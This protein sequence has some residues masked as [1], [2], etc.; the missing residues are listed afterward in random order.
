MEAAGEWVLAGSGSWQWVSGSWQ[1]VSGFWQWVSGSWQ[2]VSGFWLAVGE[3]VLAAGEW[4]L[5]AGEWVL[6]GSG[7]WQWVS[8]SWQ[9]VSGSWQWV[10]GSWQRVSGFWQWVSG[11]WQWVSGFWLAVG[12]WVLAAG[13]WVLA[14]GEWVLAGSGSW[15]WVSGSWQRVSGS[16]QWVSGSWQRVSGF[17][18]WVSG[19]WQWV[20]GFW[21]WVSGSWQWVS[22]SWQRVSGSWQW[23]SGSWQ[24]V[25]AVGERLPPGTPWVCARCGIWVWEGGGAVLAMCCPHPLLP[26]RG[27]LPPPSLPASPGTLAMAAPGRAQRSGLLE[28]RGPGERWLRVLVLLGE[29]T[30]SFTPEPEPGLPEEKAVNGGE[31]DHGNVPD[32]IINLRRTVRVVKQEAGGLGVSIKGGRENKMPILISKIFK[33][34]AADLTGAL[35]IGDAI[36]SV[37]GADLS[38]ATHDDAVQALKKTG[39]EVVLEVKYMKE[40]SPFFKGSPPG[41]PTSWDSTPPTTPHKKGSPALPPRDIK[42]GKSIPLKMC[43][44]SRRFIPTDL[45]PRYLDI[46]SADGRDVLLLRGKDESTAQ[47]WFNAIHTNVSCLIPRLQEDI[48]QHL[49]KEV[50]QMGWLTE[51]LA[52]DSKRNLLAILTEKDFLLY[53]SLPHSREGFSKPAYCYPLI[54]TRLVHSGPSKNSPMYDADL[55]FALRSGTQKGVETHL[56]SVETQRELAEWTRALVDGCHSAAELIQEVTTA[57]TWGGKECALAIHIDH[58]FTLF[59]EEPG[60]N[61]IVHLHKPFEKLRMSSDDGARMLYLDFGNPDGE[62]KLDLHSCPKTI[63][64][65]IHAFLSAKVSRLGLLA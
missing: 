62:L 4:V 26:A 50:K 43:Y 44:V 15:Q 49:G 3:W 32:S 11:S 14:A 25:L 23:V 1:W 8:G 48:K 39:K 12:E 46:I 30:L 41:G 16:W 63:V 24:W 2:W 45:E 28:L 57:C 19:S 55:A 61:K 18:Q 29:E 21:Q 42:D 51:Q 64:F 52:Q 6:A 65:I 9:R 36:L 10:S 5:A 58:G 7:S 22:G 47:S 54:A 38:E 20:S 60:L 53:N 56:F 31:P 17:W 59:T 40:I 35:Y 33:G 27:G 37:N 34:L 13:E